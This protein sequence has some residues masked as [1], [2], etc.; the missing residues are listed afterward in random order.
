M[1]L[2]DESLKTLRSSHL[3]IVA[4]AATAFV[5]LFAPFGVDFRE[6][7]EEARSL[8]EIDIAEYETYLRHLVA[9]PDVL[10]DSGSRDPRGAAGQILL[11][12]N[13]R[14]CCVSSLGSPDWDVVPALKYPPIPAGGPLREW[15]QWMTATAPGEYWRPD[16]SSAVV[17]QDTR[18][19]ERPADK[20]QR[21]L[22]SFAVRPLIRRAFSVRPDESVTLVSS[23][24]TFLAFFEDGAIPSTAPRVDVW[25]PQ[26]MELPETKLWDPDWRHGLDRSGRSVVEGL[27]YS[28]VSKSVTGEGEGPTAE[29]VGGLNLWLRTHPRWKDLF[30]PAKAGERALALPHLAEHWSTLG[31]KPLGEA[32][33][34]MQREQR[35]VMDVSLFGLSVPGPLCI[36]AIPLVFLVS[37]LNLYVHL[38]SCVSV[39]N[40]AEERARDHFPWIG[41]YPDRLSSTLTTL[42]LTLVPV[43][44][45]AGL[46]IRYRLRVDVASILT[47]TLLGIA[48]LAV[49]VLAAL[50]ASALRA[51]WRRLS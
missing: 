35:K 8:R 9:S 4:I 43:T 50:Q 28:R 48:A 41:I 1:H 23:Q 24:Y 45:M 12:L 33:D 46:L 22:R 2:S 18:G 14:V 3:V 17:S 34:F 27:V 39:L 26:I 32:I 42:S 21:I 30:R 51:K 40:E 38:C 20:N 16:W 7:L 15:L 31:D 11:F 19:L 49:G 29:G 25:W 6:A 44:L 5:L 10:P 36:V 13:D 37:L 47:G